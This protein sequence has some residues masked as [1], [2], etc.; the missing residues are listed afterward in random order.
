MQKIWM[1][2]TMVKKGK[3]LKRI[4]KKEISM[5]HKQQIYVKQNGNK[6]GTQMT[7]SMEKKGKQLWTKHRKTMET[8][9]TTMEH[10]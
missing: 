10:K 7:K 9:G 1:E 5:A 2:T 3:T 4:K 8:H 6:Y